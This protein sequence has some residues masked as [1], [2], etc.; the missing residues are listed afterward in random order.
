MGAPGP[1]QVLVGHLLAFLSQTQDTCSCGRSAPLCRRRCCPP[2]LSALTGVKRSGVATALRP[3][4]PRGRTWRRAG[5]RRQHDAGCRWGRTGGCRCC[6]PPAFGRGRAGALRGGEVALSSGAPAVIF[7]AHAA[8]CRT[9]QAASLHCGLLAL[10]DSRAG[11]HSPRHGGEQLKGAR[12][13]QTN[14]S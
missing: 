3:G 14:V 5:V 1:A 9:S 10:S 2:A 13:P 8:G 11:Y 6:M 4:H 12:R 7:C